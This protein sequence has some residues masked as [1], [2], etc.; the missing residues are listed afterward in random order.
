MFLHKT[1]YL[2][3][4]WQTII[5]TTYEQHTLLV[6]HTP[7]FLAVCLHAFDQRKYF[8]SWYV[9]QTLVLDKFI[10]R[11]SISGS[12]MKL[13]VGDAEKQKKRKETYSGK[14]QTQHNSSIPSG[15]VKVV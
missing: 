8:R 12:R 9:C 1:F 6:V 14:Q 13:I 5:Y 4:S 15:R 11:E 7:F 10:V 3:K 2:P